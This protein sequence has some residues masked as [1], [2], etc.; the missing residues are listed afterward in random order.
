MEICKEDQLKLTLLGFVIDHPLQHTGVIRRPSSNHE[1]WIYANH[2][3][4]KR[5]E[6]HELDV[7]LINYRIWYKASTV[8]DIAK[9]LVEED[10]E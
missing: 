10:A 5:R 1:L 4:L 8:L 7:T 9:F 6:K 3:T 2:F